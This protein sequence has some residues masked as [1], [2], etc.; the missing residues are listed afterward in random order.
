MGLQLSLDEN[1]K[2]DVFDRAPVQ[3]LKLLV[4][5]LY[6]RLTTIEHTFLNVFSFESKYL[7]DDGNFTT[8]IYKN[9]KLLRD[10]ASKKAND[11]IAYISHQITPLGCY[12]SRM[13]IDLFDLVLTICTDA[14]YLSRIEKLPPS[15]VRPKPNIRSHINLGP[16]RVLKFMILTMCDKIQRLTKPNNYLDLFTYGSKNVTFD[17]HLTPVER[18]YDCK[19]LVATDTYKNG[20]KISAI[21]NTFRCH[22]TPPLNL[23]LHS[24]LSTTNDCVS[25][26]NMINYQNA[27]ICL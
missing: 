18:Y 7:F 17:K 5:E 25:I 24:T 21:K 15:S 4:Y 13:N 20:D 23:L 1:K 16:E 2:E 19:L 27:V 8:E 26:W 12:D 22:V 9:C 6:D 3:V 10:V 14:K 11:E